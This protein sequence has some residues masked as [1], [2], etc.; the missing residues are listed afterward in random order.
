MDG[1]GLSV[2]LEQQLAQLRSGDHLCMFYDSDAERLGAVTHF[3][4]DGLARGERCLCVVG[5]EGPESMARAL[6]AVGLDAAAERRRGALLFESA[7]E[8]YLPHGSFDHDATRG[9][10]SR[11]EHDAREAGFAGLRLAGDVPEEIGRGPNVD[12]WISHEARLNGLLS[13]SHTRMLCQYDLRQFKTRLILEA[14]RLHATVLLG[15]GAVGPERVHWLLDL[16]RRLHASEQEAR[17]LQRATLAISG[18][19]DLDTRLERVLDAALEL[20][21]AEHARIILEVPETGEVEFAAVRG[22]PGRRAGDRQPR[23]VGLIGAVLAQ[24]SPVRLGDALADPRTW[25]RET[26]R[27]AGIRSWFGVPLVDGDRPFG[28]LLVVSQAVDRFS[29][30]DA[31][32]LLALAALAGSA[33]REARLR[34]ELEQELDERR[35]AEAALR[36]V[37]ET[38]PDMVTRI[39]R[40]L[41]YV[42]VNAAFE[43]A[44]GVSSDQ[45][46]GRLAGETDMT[47]PVAET[48]R[49]TLR[50]VFASGRE[51]TVELPARV[52]GQE[53]VLQLRAAPELGPDGR[54]EHIVAVAR[55]VTERARREEEQAR[56]YHELMER[57]ERLHA[58]ARRALL[59]H[60]QEQR[61]LRGLAELEQLTRREQETL[62]LL[63]RGLTTRQIAEQLAIKP[64]TAK[65]YIE[66]VLA[67]LGVGNRTQAAARAM[68][69]GLLEGHPPADTPPGTDDVDRTGHST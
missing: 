19:L 37:V 64:G 42:Y 35:R 54:V 6:A 47:P 29:E 58:L 9:V 12:R 27:R 18:E 48:W 56:L 66:H 53:R 46:L 26:M 55:D 51:Q 21:G 49:L 52:A 23:E 16:V 65:S 45:L 20:T 11:A 30:A 25:D 34:R 60:E 22:S 15:R 67:K 10:W 69:L 7:A 43:R 38:A 39:D 2:E 32:C 3:L 57:D 61:R 44:Q 62:R 63:A 68:E 59:A 40:D 1:V 36:A 24:N 50:Q 33:I 8:Y 17:S 4:R 5:E 41:R 14:L 31:Q 13:G 28:V